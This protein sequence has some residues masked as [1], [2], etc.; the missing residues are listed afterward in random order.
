VQ[1]LGTRWTRG[2]ERIRE[3]VQEVLPLRDPAAFPILLAHHPHCF[4]YAASA[5][6]PL[7]LAG[8]THGGQLMLNERIGF[9]PL[10]FR[11][12]T[13]M[14]EKAGSKL[15]VSNG[16]GNWFPLRTAAPAEIIQVTLRRA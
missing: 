4:D 7:T 9:G 1:L 12:W 11:Y 14:Y 16:A 5:G 10:M 13:G 8:H 2:E 6:I 3:T 15:I